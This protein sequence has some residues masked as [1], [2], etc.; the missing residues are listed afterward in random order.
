M[1]NLRMHRWRVLYGYQGAKTLRINYSTIEVKTSTIGRKIN[2]E[3]LDW[4]AI[5]KLQVIFIRRL[6]TFLLSL[7]G[8]SS[9]R[10]A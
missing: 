5:R 7:F 9:T 3:S 8:L 4:V 1:I 6:F 10:A 2:G